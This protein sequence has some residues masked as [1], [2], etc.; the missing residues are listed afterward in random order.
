MVSTKTIDGNGNLFFLYIYIYIKKSL[1]HYDG[2]WILH[3][4]VGIIYLKKIHFIYSLF[5]VAYWHMGFSSSWLAGG[6]SMSTR[7]C[8]VLIKISTN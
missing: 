4:G 3:M 2:I 1:S 6:V 7:S 8:F 5:V